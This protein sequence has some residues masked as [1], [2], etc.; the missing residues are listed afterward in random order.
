MPTKAVYALYDSSIACLRFV[1]GDGTLVNAERVCFRN[2][3]KDETSN[4]NR[5]QRLHFIELMNRS[6]DHY[7]LMSESGEFRSR[8][9]RE[10]PTESS[11]RECPTNSGTL[12]ANI[13]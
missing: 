8:V 2:T 3:F 10:F 4:L 7:R 12:E 9:A 5:S 1:H 13:L 11:V 6:V